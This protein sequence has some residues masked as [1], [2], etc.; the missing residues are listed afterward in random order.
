MKDCNSPPVVMQMVAGGQTTS[1]S[2]QAAGGGSWGAAGITAMSNQ[3]PN[4]TT[5]GAVPAQPQR[6]PLNPA[7]PSQ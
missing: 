7:G 5:Q 2:G 4:A 6:T 1:S 3:Q